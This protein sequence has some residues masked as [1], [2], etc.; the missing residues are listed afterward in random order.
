MNNL[1]VNCLG[2][3][4]AALLL[5]AYYLISKGAVK[6]NSPKYQFLNVIGSV[7][8]ITNSAYFRA[9]PSVAVNLFWIIIAF[10]TLFKHRR[11]N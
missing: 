1:I 11:A 10:T 6:G 4:G 7:L 2:W 5:Y 9:F 8:L 3:F